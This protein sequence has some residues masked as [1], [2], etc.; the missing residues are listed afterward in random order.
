MDT[1]CTEREIK[2]KLHFG[3]KTAHLLFQKTRFARG[4]Y[5]TSYSE[6]EHEKIRSS[7][8]LLRLSERE[9]DFLELNRGPETEELPDE[10]GYKRHELRNQVKDKRSQLPVRFRIL[11]EDIEELYWNDYFDGPEWEEIIDELATVGS[12]FAHSSFGSNRYEQ[13]PQRPY[14]IGAL[15]GRLTAHMMKYPPSIGEKELQ[16]EVIWGFIENFCFTHKIDYTPEMRSEH[17]RE[18]LELLRDRSEKAAT[19]HKE[20]EKD[21]ADWYQSTNSHRSRI[22]EEIDKVLENNGVELPNYMLYE[23]MDEVIPEDEKHDDD[24][25]VEIVDSHVSSKKVLDHAIDLQLVEKSQLRD[26]LYED[27][28]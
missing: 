23:I 1:S 9:Y 13:P 12:H 15:F 18:L 2:E 4:L 26:I 3:V 14:G 16:S 24:R 17:T 5:E 11:Y 20:A 6:S 22:L 10:W 8:K 7:R 21:A 28:N 27:A 19:E 25:T